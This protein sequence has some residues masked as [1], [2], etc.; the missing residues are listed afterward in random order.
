MHLLYNLSIRFFGLM[1]R[2][3]SLFNTKAK[4][5]LTGRNNWEISLTEKIKND[6]DFIWFHCSSLGEFEQ[7]RPI[8]EALKKRG[9]KVILTFFSPSGYE[10]LKNF[11]GAYH[12]CYIP[13]DT[14]YNAKKWMELINPK[15]ILF[16]KY[17]FWYNFIL[18]AKKGNIPLFLISGIF[19]DDH[20]FFKSYGKWFAKQLMSFAHFF[21]QDEKS[22]ELL[23]TIGIKHVS[24]SGDTRFDRVIDISLN[25]KEMSD[26]E[27]FCSEGITIV[28]GSTWPEDENLL[29]QLLDHHNNL[30]IILVPHDVF[31]ERIQKLLVKT[32]KKA[33]LYSQ[34]NSGILS[35]ILIIDK[36]GFLSSIYKYGQ[37]AYIGGGF[38]KGIHN[39]LEA[40]IYGVPVI[41][42]PNYQKFKEAINMVEQNSAFSIKNF[43]ELNERISMLLNETE[44][45]KIGQENKEFVFSQQGATKKILHHLEGLQLIKSL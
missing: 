26:I 39:T 33:V 17:E 41:F 34:I 21:V 43:D 40:A 19:R 3:M 8:I 12:V 13:L 45:R 31:E 29:L 24:L 10:N 42:G 11:N 22:M 7:G 38:G 15:V 44:R 6:S 30:K 5:W 18:Q 23:R 1:M 27:S 28:A 9:E 37:I 35:R 16:V 4:Q 36:V 2:L 32:N 25:P 20:Y 14:T